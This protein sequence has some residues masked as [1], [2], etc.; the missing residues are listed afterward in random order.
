MIEQKLSTEY[1]F[2][3]YLIWIWVLIMSKHIMNEV[4]Y[5]AE[6]LGLNIYYQDTGS[7]LIYANEL[8]SLE[9]SFNKRYKEN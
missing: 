7:F 2:N 3:Y 4:M 6:D 5:L 8:R 9:K 1:Q